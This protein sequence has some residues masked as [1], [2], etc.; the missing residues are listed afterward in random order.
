LFVGLGYSFYFD[1]HNALMA[2]F[3]VVPAKELAFALNAGYN[4][5][6]LDKHWQPNLGAEFMMIVGPPDPDRRGKLILINLVPGIRYDFNEIHSLNGRLWVSYMPE[7]KPFR[8]FPTGL[9]F[10]YG[11]NFTGNGP[12]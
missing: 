8:A 9:E 3:Q 7:K 1:E 6:F 11:Y 5:Y 2:S 12:D 4:Y 10:K